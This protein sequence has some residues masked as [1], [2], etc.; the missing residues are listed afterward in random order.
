[1]PKKYTKK[2]RKSIKKTILVWKVLAYTGMTKEEYVKHI[3][4]RLGNAISDCYLCDNWDNNNPEDDRYCN[5]CPLAYKDSTGDVR[6]CYAD[7]SYFQQFNVAS[8]DLDEL[9]ES[10]LHTRKN[11]RQASARL[12]VKMMEDALKRGRPEFKKSE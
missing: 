1:M 7:R 3:D 12:I 2:E 10:V 4:K 11:T 9:S 6:S 8:R 5:Q